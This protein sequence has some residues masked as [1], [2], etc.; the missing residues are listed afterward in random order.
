MTNNVKKTILI[1]SSS[2]GQGHMATARAL[3]SAAQYHPELNVDVKIIDFSEEISKLFNKTS[4]KVYEINTK[5]LPALY[6]WMY[7]ST[8][9][10]HTPIRLANL[11]NYPLRQAHL[12]RLLAAN[13]PDLIISNYPIWQYLA[14]QISKKNFPEVEFATLITDSISVHSSWVTPDSDFYIVANEPTASSLHALGVNNNKIYTLGY[15]VHESFT[16]D[17]SD[18]APSASNID[19]KLDQR[20]ILFSA[21]ALRSS[22]VRQVCSEIINN[23]PNY[24]LIVVAGRDQDLYRQIKNDAIWNNPYIQLV[25]WTNQMPELIKASDIVI[26]KAGGS[27]VMEC[28]AAKKP[29]I[30]NKIIPGQEEG[31]AELVERYRLGHIAKSDHEIIMAINEINNDYSNYQ[32]RL[33]TLSKPEAAN[34]IIKFLAQR[35][36]GQ[37]A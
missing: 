24:R 7:I 21:S 8:D 11:L 28:I 12:K 27:T 31:N 10:T 37:S 29:L 19:T 15:P 23:Y 30:I 18:T 25:G 20:I 9:I 22:Y 16:A 33:S 4:K 35:L 32:K 14:L 5:H 6:K 2:F 1:L 13:K 34:T 36:N 26:T 3:E 17:K